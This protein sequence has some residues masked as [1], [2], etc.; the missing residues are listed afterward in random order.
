MSPS[1]D[2]FPFPDS[3]LVSAYPRGWVKLH[4]WRGRIDIQDLEFFHRNHGLFSPIYL[5]IQSLI[6]I[7]LV[8]WM[9]TLP[10]GL[11][12]MLCYLLF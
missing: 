12:Q 10:S 6:W 8:S 1:S 4:L 5:L 9:S 2:L 11:N 7:S 3:S